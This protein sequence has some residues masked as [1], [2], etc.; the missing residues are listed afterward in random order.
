VANP[1]PLPPPPNFR[2]AGTEPTHVRLS[3]SDYPLEYR[4]SGRLHGFRLYRSSV[5]GELGQRIADETT[6]RT[7]VFQY[8]DHEANA[9]ADRFYSL[10]AVESCGW[11]DGPFDSGPYGQPDAGGF[12]LMPFN[13]RPWG[14]PVRGWNESPYG[15]EPFGF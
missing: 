15:V 14:T 12:D 5:K 6:L 9:G 2:V 4:T 8:D 3:W 1:F 13:S 11:G 7:G 10:V